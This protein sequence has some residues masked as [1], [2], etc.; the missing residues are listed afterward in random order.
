MN[1]AHLSGQNSI[2]TTL[3]TSRPNLYLWS[4]AWSVATCTW[5]QSPRA[6]TATQQ[7]DE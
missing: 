2:R 1:L 5:L 4:S 7:L 3:A 6:H